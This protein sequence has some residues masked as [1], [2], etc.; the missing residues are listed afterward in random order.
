[1]TTTT[2]VSQARLDLAIGSCLPE[3]L[4]ICSRNTRITKEM[5]LCDL[6]RI[7]DL[8]TGGPAYDYDRQCWID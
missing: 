7:H 5:L 2:T 3:M 8:L 6:Q 4:D 1:M